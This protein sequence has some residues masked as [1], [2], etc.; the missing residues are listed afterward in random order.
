MV[1][2]PHNIKTSV[3]SVGASESDSQLEF[4]ECL[5]LLRPFSPFC[6]LKSLLATFLRFIFLARAW[7]LKLKLKMTK[8]QVLPQRTLRNITFVILKKIWWKWHY[9][10]GII[11]KQHVLKLKEWAEQYS[12]VWPSNQP[13][14]FRFLMKFDWDMAV[15]ELK[16]LDY[17]YSKYSGHSRAT[18]HSCCYHH[19]I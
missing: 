4:W 13:E 18:T 11:I 9:V 1:N 14:Q 8:A 19:V 5:L 17:A 10:G 6:G 3:T 16:R 7:N 15:Y 2:D 12:E